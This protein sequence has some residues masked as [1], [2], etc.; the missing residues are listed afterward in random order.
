MIASGSLLV[1]EKTDLEEAI[2]RA[3]N[4]TVDNDTIAAIVGAAVGALHGKDAIPERWISNLLGRTTEGDDGR[5]FELLDEVP[6]IQDA[7][8]AIELPRIQGEIQFDEV[9]FRYG[10]GAPSGPTADE[11]VLHHEFSVQV[12]Q[13]IAVVVASFAPRRQGESRH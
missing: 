4:D 5:I 12:F 7:P 8:G 13:R 2:V 6:E 11:H 3:V 10:A 1:A 9:F